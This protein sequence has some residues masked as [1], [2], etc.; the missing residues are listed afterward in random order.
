[1]I[2]H[3]TIRE[4]GCI[5]RGYC[6][7]NPDG[8]K[9]ELWYTPERWKE[10]KH[11]ARFYFIKRKYGINEESYHDMLQSQGEMCAICGRQFLESKNIH[12]D[13]DHKTLTIRGLLCTQCNVIL[14]S[15]H[16]DI[17]VL[18]NAITYLKKF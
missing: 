1:M 18:E 9:R 7:L 16:D 17:K 10:Q 15:A 11:K 8:S 6:G 12:V 2:K 13:H 3:G 5:F 4:D 14:G